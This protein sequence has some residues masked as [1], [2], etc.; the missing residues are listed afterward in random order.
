MGKL[1]SWS[2]CV[3]INIKYTW[4]GSWVIEFSFWVTNIWKRLSIIALLWF[5]DF[6]HYRLQYFEISQ[7]LIWKFYGKFLTFL[8]SWWKFHDRILVYSK[9]S[10]KKNTHQVDESNV[11][12]QMRVGEVWNWFWMNGHELNFDFERVLNSVKSRWAAFINSYLLV[13]EFANVTS[14]IIQNY[15]ILPS[16]TWLHTFAVNVPALYFL[17]KCK[18]MFLI[19]IYESIFEVFTEPS[20]REKNPNKSSE[21]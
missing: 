16:F 5:Y 17:K 9:S 3:H 1:H 4:L 8:H 12:L 10:R 15:L 20:N 2:C 21:E 19:F 11:C 18:K 6:Y 13:V 14:E 7:S